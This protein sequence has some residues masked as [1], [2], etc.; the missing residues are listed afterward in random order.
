MEG[1]RPGAPLHDIVTREPDWTALPPAVRQLVGRCLT[2]DPRRRLRDIGEARVALE[3]GTLAVED[4]APACAAPT[5]A[6]PT[7]SRTERI[8][9][10]GRVGLRTGG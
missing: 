10:V 6:R 4:P 8:R 7:G 1:A 9:A 3:D 2:R 5:P